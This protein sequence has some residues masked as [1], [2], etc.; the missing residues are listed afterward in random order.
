MIVNEI[1]LKSQFYK[2]CILYVH[3]DVKDEDLTVGFLLIKVCIQS[4]ITDDSS[5]SIQEQGL[6]YQEV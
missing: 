5:A 4:L 1:P 2:Y 6:K 3:A